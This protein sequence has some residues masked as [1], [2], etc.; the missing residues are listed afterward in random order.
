M[1]KKYKFRYNG[2]KEMFFSRFD[3]K[4]GYFDDK[5]KYSYIGNYM[6]KMIGNKILFGV[7]H[8]GHSGGFWFIPKI[9]EFNDHIECVG[10]IKYIS[11]SDSVIMRFCEKIFE[12][13]WFILLLPF[14]IIFKT[15]ELIR[16]LIKKPINKG[17]STE[18]KLFDFMINH[19]DC[20]KV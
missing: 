9:K 3:F 16:I 1:L 6:L 12:G 20:I 14:F 17:Q 19:L 10:R 7:N 2:T 5:A 13:I 8:G 4:D 18:D 11:S 15:Y